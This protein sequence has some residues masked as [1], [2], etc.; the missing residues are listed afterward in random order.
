MGGAATLVATSQG[1]VV[2][3]IPAVILWSPGIGDNGEFPGQEF[4]ELP[5]PGAT[6][7]DEAGQ[8]VQA[9]FWH[10]AHNAGFFAAL[11][12]FNGAI[13][14]VLGEH[15]HFDP[16]GLRFHAIERFKGRDHSVTVLAGQDHSSWD[17]DVAQAVYGLERDFLRAHLP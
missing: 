6:Y 1:Q 11:D 12:A 9:D 5:F 15:D 2:D 3:R 4:L 13:H 17:Y 14:M 7:V 10:E 16:D 8:R